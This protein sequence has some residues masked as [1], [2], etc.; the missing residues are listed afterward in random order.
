MISHDAEG[1]VFRFVAHVDPTKGSRVC[2]HC[3]VLDQEQ[4]L[5]SIEERWHEP[6]GGSPEPRAV[7][8]EEQ[9]SAQVSGV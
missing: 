7:S 6:A 8:V 3:E 2:D 5:V 4:G 1:F 9:L